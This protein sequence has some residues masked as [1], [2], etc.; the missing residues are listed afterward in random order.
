[1]TEQTTVVP[2]GVTIA[3]AGEY[4]ISIPSGTSGIGVTLVDNETGI[5]TNLAL[6][7][8]TVA[9][10]AGTQNDRFYL[11]ISPIKHVATGVE[12]ITGDGS[13]VTGARKVM[14]DGILYIIKDG[15]VFSTQG[16]RV[17]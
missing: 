7:D 17:K 13:Q 1:M 11:E 5:R 3:K 8:Y 10:E 16:A 4:T 12:E 15:K 6:E 2:M 9:L 14:V